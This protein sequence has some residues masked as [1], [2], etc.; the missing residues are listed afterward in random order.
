MRLS[1]ENLSFG[2]R[3]QPVLQSI[4]LTFPDTG[5]TVLLGGNGCGK[6]TLLHT[7]AGLLK[8]QTG[9]V[10]LDQTPFAS[11]G[12]KSIARK[13]SLLPQMTS[14]PA[15]V[16]VRE[17]VMQGRFP[18]QTWWRQ[19]SKADQLAVD[20]AIQAT[21]IEELVE[22]PLEQLSGGQRQRCWVAMTLAQDT[23]ILLLDEPTTY[24]DIA[25][26]VELMNLVSNLCAQ[27]KSVITVL[28]DLNQA[29]AYADHMIMMQAGRVYAQGDVETVF[30]QTNLKAV[31][32]L[33]ADIIREPR[34]Q[35]LLC[36][37][38]V[39]GDEFANTVQM[40]LVGQS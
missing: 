5:L 3:N 4:D 20:E 27:G 12:R 37:P 24:L 11:M 22:R 32:N 39:A 19:W 31:F 8:P 33:D 34:R 21:G 25:H 28:H 30:T 38:H 1:V 16:T 29:A 6:T 26:Q 15:G 40:S 17:L 14:A 35:Q 36:V 23:P 10:I 18:W 2:Y 13:L 9:Q 7:L